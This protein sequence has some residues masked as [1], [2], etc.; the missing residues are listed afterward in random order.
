MAEQEFKRPLRSGSYDL[1]TGHLQHLQA[2]QVVG[3]RTSTSARHPY[4]NEGLH[5]KQRAAAV[6]FGAVMQVFSEGSG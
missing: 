2:T 5:R 4:A 6:E 1:S 3:R